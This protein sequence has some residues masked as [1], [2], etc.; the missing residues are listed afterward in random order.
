MIPTKCIYST[1]G[2]KHMLYALFVQ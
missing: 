2:S 1:G